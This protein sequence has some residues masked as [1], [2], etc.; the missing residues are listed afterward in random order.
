MHPAGEPRSILVIR[1]GAVGDVVRTLPAVSCLKRTFPFARITWT[2]EEPSREILEGD[3]EIDE[4]I[5]LRRRAL[6]AGLKLR[7]TLAALAHLREYR[8]ALRGRTFDWAVD[9][10]GTLKSALIARSSGAP[11]TFG[12]GRAHAREWSHLLYTDP[13]AIPAGKMS[14]VARALT[15]VE[16]LGADVSSPRHRLP[17][18]EGPSSAAREFLRSA[19]PA[20]PR[21]L[22]CPGTSE[23]QAYKR[24]PAD[25]FARLA[26]RIAEEAG[27]SVV[28]AWGPGEEPIAEEVRRSM[29]RAA[30]LTPPTRLTD[31]AELAREC[32]LF[33]ASDTG[34]LHIAAAV[35]VPLLALYGPTDP[36]VNA[37]YT[38]APY[39]SFVGD[40]TCRPCRNRGCQ[41]RACLKLIDPDDTARQ[42]VATLLN[43]NGAR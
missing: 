29:R 15:F 21:V 27:A 2:V 10:Q 26:D 17:K 22:V 31:L 35:G 14:R 34:P 11:R 28:I 37:P 43:G 30:V 41:N 42:A 16:A 3:P 19:A 12:F 5:V 36:I 4:V 40:V 6:V 7:G 1:L 8:A 13:V 33:V 32:D 24:Y 9:L 39:L 20:R 25:L 38:D 23:A 18:R